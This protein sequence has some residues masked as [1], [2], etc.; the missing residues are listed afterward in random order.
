MADFSLHSAGVLSAPR[1]LV[2][3]HL[4]D[5]ESVPG[6]LDGVDAVTGSGER[7]STRRSKSGAGVPIEGTVL[8]V[9]PQRRI[10]L[11][12]RA[13]WRL[14]REIELCIDLLPE[15][16]GTRVELR[17]AYRLRWLGR[18]LRPLVHL[19]AEVALHRATRGFRSAVEDDVARERRAA[20]DERRAAPPFAY[21]LTTH[22]ALLRTLPD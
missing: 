6:W 13:P 14:L 15:D 10:R 9:A 8:E 17:A 18:L 20:K 12:L 5:R 2:W 22:E 3:R 21:P 19:H 7:F 16:R 11:V 4:V 1:A